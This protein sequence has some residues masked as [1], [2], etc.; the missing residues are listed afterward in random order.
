MHFDTNETSDSD[1]TDD[2]KVSTES[3]FLEKQDIKPF[4]TNKCLDVS[5]NIWLPNNIILL[6]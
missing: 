4:W 1:T 3:S 6:W 2:D 5:K